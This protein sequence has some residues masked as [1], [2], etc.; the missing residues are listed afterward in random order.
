MR[1]IMSDLEN[2]GFLM[3]PHTS[4]G[5]VPSAKGFRFFVDHLLTARPPDEALINRLRDNVRGDT[6]ADV[7]AAAA[8][9]VSQLTRFAG[10]VAAPARG[11]LR[12]QQLRFVKLSSSRVLTV[13]VTVDGEIINRI[14]ECE[15]PPQERDLA[16]AARFFN[17]YLCDLTF[18]EAKNRLREEMKNLR[19]EISRLLAGMMKTIDNKLADAEGT[20][21]V[22]G[23]LNLLNQSELTA[24]VRNLRQLYALFN[25][26]KEFFSIID[27]GSRAEDVCV[28][29]GNEC[30]H[31]ALSECSLVLSPLG[32]DDDG[33]VLGYLGVIGPKR[34]RYQ[35]VIATVD[36]A[37][38]LVSHSLQQLRLEEL[39][40]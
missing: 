1:N 12:I 5:R 24:D 18:E 14:F 4:A 34:M 13:V 7:L 37:S 20:I 29:I 15:R 23:E 32:H 17:R 25:K 35:Q 3:S 6:A 33:T 8:N 16:A 36:V 27:R 2:M 30:G 22:A 11:T 40:A 38:K 9:T 21:Q 31:D 10:F 26:K 19:G 28:F 39:N